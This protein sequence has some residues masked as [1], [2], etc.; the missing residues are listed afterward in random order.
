MNGGAHLIILLDSGFDF[1]CRIA[2][3]TAATTGKKFAI[4]DAEWSEW[5]ERSGSCRTAR[6]AESE[7]GAERMNASTGTGQTGNKGLIRK[8]GKHEE[9]EDKLMRN[10]E[11]SGNRKLEI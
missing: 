2:A 4:A 6:V 7:A 9:N 11:R 10:T 3:D 5:V 8:P 1:E